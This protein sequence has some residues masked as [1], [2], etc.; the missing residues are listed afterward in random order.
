MMME[1]GA[2]GV[3]KMEGSLTL[4]FFA[5]HTTFAMFSDFTVAVK[6]TSLH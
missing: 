3:G 6:N 1:S 4:L 5:K 2:L